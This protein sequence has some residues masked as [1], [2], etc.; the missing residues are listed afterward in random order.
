MPELSLSGY[1]LLAPRKRSDVAITALHPVSPRGADAV[2]SVDGVVVG[3][4]AELG[5]DGGVYN[6][7]AVVDGTGILA[8]YRKTISGTKRTDLHSG[9]RDPTRCARRL[10]ASSA[11]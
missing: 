5:D 11:S 3:G 8:V 10:S 4:F 1:M 7:A 6:S 9:P 2:A